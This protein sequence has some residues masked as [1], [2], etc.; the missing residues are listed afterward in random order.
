[1]GEDSED[2]GVLEYNYVLSQDATRLKKTPSGFL[3]V[4]LARLPPSG[5]ASEILAIPKHSSEEKHHSTSAALSHCYAII[6]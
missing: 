4:V 1:M 6:S 3:R 2:L 5:L